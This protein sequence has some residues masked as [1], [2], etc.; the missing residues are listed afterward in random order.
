METLC[1]SI[2][3]DISKRIIAFSLPNSTL[4][5]ARDSSVFPTPVLPK[6]RK[7]AT[8]LC[9]FLSPVRPR[10][11]AR[12]TA[13][14]ARSC[15]I[16]RFCNAASSPSSFFAVSSSGFVTG[17]PVHCEITREMS[18]GRTCSGFSSLSRV[19]AVRRSAS[20]ASSSVSFS[21]R[22]A[23]AA[24]FCALIA[25]SFSLRS[26]ASSSCVCCRS[27]GRESAQIRIREAASSIRSMALSGRNR[28][29]R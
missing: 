10:L 8:G 28:S 5:S 17:I 20:F 24:K 18:S 22:D 27:G 19:Y 25:A 7:E 29:G 2:Y 15:P 1:R 11:T 21:C 3:S 4:A 16:M 13:S 23:A 9:G 26:A 6:N 12:Q 14:M